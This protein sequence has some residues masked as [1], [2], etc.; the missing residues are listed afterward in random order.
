MWNIRPDQVHK[1][2]THMADRHKGEMHAI[3]LDWRIMQ[4]VHPRY[5]GKVEQLVP[6]VVIDFK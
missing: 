2:F 6:L 5:E 3:Y 1:M 4:I